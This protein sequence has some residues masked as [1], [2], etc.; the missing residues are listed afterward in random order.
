MPFILR[1]PLFFPLL[2]LLLPELVL[3]HR[4][5]HEIFMRLY[6]HRHADSKKKKTTYARMRQLVKYSDRNKT[7]R[8]D[9]A[10]YLDG[11]AAFV[12]VVAVAAVSAVDVG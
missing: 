4:Y 2:F 3:P 10:I 12:V 8:F 11:A 1:I 7:Y 9:Y 6:R 5:G